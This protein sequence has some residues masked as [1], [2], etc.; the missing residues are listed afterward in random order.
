MTK[1]RKKEQNLLKQGISKLKD[2]I[3]LLK[4]DI[5]KISNSKG[6]GFYSGEGQVHHKALKRTLS[7]I[8]KE[9]ILLHNTIDVNLRR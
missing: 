3:S 1:V 4:N 9:L 7:A 2:D 5:L 8:H 6:G